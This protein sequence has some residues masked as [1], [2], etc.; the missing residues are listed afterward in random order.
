MFSPSGAIRWAAEYSFMAGSDPT[1]LDVLSA[2]FVAARV[3][4]ERGHAALTHLHA[5]LRNR[6]AREV[7]AAS[8]LRDS[9]AASPDDIADTVLT[10]FIRQADARKLV[11]DTAGA[12]LA[13]AL[14]NAI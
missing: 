7:R 11:P 2:E 1:R 8:D 13:V 6:A 10:R 5:E 3:R 12:Y 14:R 9:W 4:G